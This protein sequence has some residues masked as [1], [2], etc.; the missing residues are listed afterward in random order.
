M[1]KCISIVKNQSSNYFDLPLLLI[2]ELLL[3]IVKSKS[4]NYNCSNL[5][6]NES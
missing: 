1:D 3:F 4:D 2:N 5:I 6:Y